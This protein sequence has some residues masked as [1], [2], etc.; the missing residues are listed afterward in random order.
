MI[1]T[2]K[3][4]LSIA[5][6]PFLLIQILSFIIEVDEVRSFVESKKTPVYIWLTIDCY[7]RAIVDCLIGDSAKRTLRERTHQSARKLWA[8]LP[9][10]YPIDLLRLAYTDFWHAYQT[11][12]PDKFHRAVGK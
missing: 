9:D 8:S 1:L 2:R 10:I 3:W 4:L 11:V 5:R 12:I 7:S 6:S